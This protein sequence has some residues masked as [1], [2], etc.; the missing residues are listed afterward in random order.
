MRLQPVCHVSG[1]SCLCCKLVCTVDPLGFMLCVAISANSDLVIAD[2]SP[3]SMHAK[4]NHSKV[5]EHAI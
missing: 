3:M 5:A 4:T 2:L 1:I